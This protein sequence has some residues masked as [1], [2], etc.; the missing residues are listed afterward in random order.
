MPGLTCGRDEIEDLGGEA[1]RHAHLLDFFGGFE[2]TAMGEPGCRGRAAGES[3]S[4][5]WFFKDSGL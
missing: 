4:S 5:A 1:A 3:E 2:L